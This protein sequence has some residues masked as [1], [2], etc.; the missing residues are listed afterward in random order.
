M[1][2]VIILRMQGYQ[3][4]M[5]KTKKKVWKKKICY[6]ELSED[7]WHLPWV[8][9]NYHFQLRFIWLKCFRL[10][11]FLYPIRTESANLRRQR[12]VTDT[13]ETALLECKDISSRC[14]KQKSNCGKSKFVS[15]RCQKTC[16]ICR[17]FKWIII[18]Y[19]TLLDRKLCIYLIWL[20]VN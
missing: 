10:C 16:G 17:E 14:A 9:M 1:L 19:F 8:Q 18:F 13:S 3:F 2:F 7:M 4:Q 20:M 5:L 15:K 12:P 6:Q 11:Y